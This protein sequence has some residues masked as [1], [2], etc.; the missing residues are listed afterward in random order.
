MLLIVTD[1]TTAECLRADCT[2]LGDNKNPGY[3]QVTFR[4]Y[5]FLALGPS[6]MSPWQ[7]WIQTH[8]WN[9]GCA[10]LRRIIL[11]QWRHYVTD[12]VAVTCHTGR[13]VQYASR[14][15]TSNLRESYLP[16]QKGIQTTRRL[17]EI[18]MARTFLH[19]NGQTEGRRP[20]WVR[21]GFCRYVVKVLSV[22][23]A[24][25][26]D[27]GCPHTRHRRCFKHGSQ[28]GKEPPV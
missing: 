25:D 3:T 9:V 26:R 12:S 16:I 20:L 23:L 8:F 4:Q 1:N 5:L 11:S 7:L 6:A 21:I 13:F 24:L 15:G 27:S 2:I 17:C 19:I 28:R 14:R 18:Y 22:I 10:C